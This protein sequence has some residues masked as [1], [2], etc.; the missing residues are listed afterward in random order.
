ML[1]ALYGLSETTA[2]VFQSMP[3]DSVEVVAET[4]G[5]TTDHCEVKVIKIQGIQLVSVKVQSETTM[6]KKI[7][8]NYQSSKHQHATLHNT[9]TLHSKHVSL[10][11]RSILKRFR[12]TLFLVGCCFVKNLGPYNFN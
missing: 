2:C 7:C 3:E 10:Q 9:S 11:L 8:T 1:Q 5:Y 4:V 6:H 12:H